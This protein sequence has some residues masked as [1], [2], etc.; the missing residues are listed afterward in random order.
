MSKTVVFDASKEFIG[1]LVQ[2]ISEEH[3]DSLIVLAPFV[4]NVSVKAPVAKGKYKGYHRFQ[5]EI[6]IPE[7]AIN[8]EGALSDFGAFAVMR[9]PKAR[10]QDHLQKKEE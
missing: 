8:G 9:L 6:C 4:G 3:P 1:N 10:V 7:E 2:G 5:L